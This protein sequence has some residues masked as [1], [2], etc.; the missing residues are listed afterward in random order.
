MTNRLSGSILSSTPEW[1]AP[2]SLG[3]TMGVAI[4]TA[5]PAELPPGLG[6]FVWICEEP[7]VVSIGVLWSEGGVV[8]PCVGTLQEVRRL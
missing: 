3:R 5:L 8:G 1:G 2:V 6:A 7:P 4:L